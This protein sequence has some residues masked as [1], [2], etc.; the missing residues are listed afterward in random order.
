[1]Q[2]NKDSDERNQ[3]QTDGEIHHVLGLEEAILCK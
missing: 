3:K 1:M 2:K